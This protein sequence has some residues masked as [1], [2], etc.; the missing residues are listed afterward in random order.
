MRQV[1]YSGQLYTV[2]GS[3][4]DATDGEMLQLTRNARA[5]I[6]ARA[7]ECREPKPKRRRIRTQQHVL[8]MA[9]DGALTVRRVRSPKRYPFT[10]ADL[11]DWA[12]RCSVMKGS[13]LPKAFR[14]RRKR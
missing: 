10:L 3:E 8:E 4:S 11:Y 2:V 14:A 12:V 7:V 6:W 1:M 5:P 13:R 9:A